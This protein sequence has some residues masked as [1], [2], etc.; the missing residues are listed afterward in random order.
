MIVLPRYN[1]R[2]GHPV[3]FRAALYGEL[4][5]APVEVGARQVV[6]NH[7]VEVAEVETDEEG[8]LLNLNDPEALRKALGH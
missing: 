7:A 6:W 1:G 2:R 3:L 4:L 8:V 5:A